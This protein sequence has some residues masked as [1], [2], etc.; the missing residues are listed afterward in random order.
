MTPLTSDGILLRLILEIKRSPNFVIQMISEAE[1]DARVSVVQSSDER[2]ALR[3]V[4]NYLYRSDGP[5][6]LRNPQYNLAKCFLNDGEVILTK[7]L[8]SRTNGAGR[9][10]YGKEALTQA[11]SV[12]YK[13]QSCGTCDVRV[14]HLDHVFG[15][16]KK[17]FLVLCANCH[18]IKSRL[19]DW[20][21][22]KRE[23][24]D[25]LNKP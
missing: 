6:N 14:L 13:C 2:S 18:N 16:L 1:I 10:D 25:A 9:K 20:L 7:Y 4:L 3:T 22:T 5:T 24:E 12:G 15:K 23:S 11:R 8:K 17:E 19:F 21:G